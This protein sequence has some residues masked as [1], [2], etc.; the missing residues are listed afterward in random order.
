MEKDQ[1]IKLYSTEIPTVYCFNTSPHF[2]KLFLI[3]LFILTDMIAE[4]QQG[5]DTFLDQKHQYVG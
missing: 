2:L 3:S 1:K 4:E 5:K